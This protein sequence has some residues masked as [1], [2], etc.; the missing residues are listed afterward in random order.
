MWE[1][2]SSREEVC[3]TEGVFDLSTKQKID[4]ANDGPTADE[5]LAVVNDYIEHGE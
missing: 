2:G 4:E 3:M 1:N 5:I